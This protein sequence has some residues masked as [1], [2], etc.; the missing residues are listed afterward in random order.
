[1]QFR[2][3]ASVGIEKHRF[4]RSRGIL[5]EAEAPAQTPAAP[6]LPAVISPSL[7]E[8]IPESV[9]R[10]NVVVPLEFDGETMT[11]ASAQP[12]DIAL[13]DRL[14]F[15]LGKNV[16]LVGA[17]RDDILRTLEQ[18]YRS[19]RKAPIERAFDGSMTLTCARCGA[20]IKIKPDWAG[21][22][23]L[24]PTCRSVN[25]VPAL[26]APARDLDML[27]EPLEA[28][29]SEVA[30]ASRSSAVKATEF[31]KGYKALEEDIDEAEDS[32]RFTEHSEGEGMFFFTVDEGQRVLMRRSNG[33]MEVIVGPRRV[34]RG[35][36]TFK[37]MAHYVAHPDE[38]LVVRFRD[39]RQ[40]HLPGP[41]DIWL[42][43]REHLSISKESAL[44]ISAKEAVVVYSR[45][46]A[47]TETS[48]GKG[49]S[50]A[51]TR[52]IVYGPALFVPR[53]GEW[54]H[55]FSWHA[56]KGG[57]R[58]VAKE[59]NALVF[60][61]LWLM[62][63]QMYHDVAD[64]R[65]ADDA[66]LTIRLMIFFELVDIDRMLEATHDPIGD[67]VNAA[68][69]DVVAFTG[70]H[71]FEQFKRNTGQLNELE[72]YPQLA[73][74][75]AQ[76]GYRINKVVY[77]GYGA[78]EALQQM[79]DQAIEARTRLQLDRA[80]EQQ[81]QDLENYKLDSQLARA[82]KRRG[83]QVQEVNHDLALAHTRHEAEM[84]EREAQLAAQRE[85]QRLEAELQLAIRRNQ[86]DQQRQHLDALRGLGVD[87]TAYLTQ[88]RAD[89]VIEFR[90][91][92]RPHVHLDG[93]TMK[94]QGDGKA[95]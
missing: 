15:L 7:L 29:Y 25:I 84:K 1:M 57:S 49:A 81:A 32:F 71:D 2:L 39:G 52:R 53:P 11:I 64:V 34:W 14:R 3:R 63:D 18:S 58:G 20:P 21:K 45:A 9:A 27:S 59:P 41:V 28:A 44:Q 77:R 70:R 12:D 90:G 61:K 31:R 88:G 23:L 72:T 85:A 67:F 94:G 8:L 93:L 40:Q 4:L 73:G 13:A 80:T 10:G 86:D 50:D 5:G 42:D 60:Q 43:P 62:P 75:A 76:C 26:A 36:N 24:C 48:Q 56:S 38:F 82:A 17:K 37:P 68:T 69:S 46:E 22:K 91:E 33:S 95:D 51:I 83:E 74:R 78:A 79:H 89:Q 30:T 6:T 66:V 47:A 87:L 16:R 92:S 65:T 35:W 55:T 19:R 54:L